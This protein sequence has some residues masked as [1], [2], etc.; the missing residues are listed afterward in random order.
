MDSSRWGFRLQ[1]VVGPNLNLS[2]GHYRTF[3]DLPA[4]RA[5]VEPGIPLLTDLDQMAFEVS[6]QPVQ[7]T[8]GSLNF[9]EPRTNTVVRAEVAFFWDEPVFIPQENI[10][11]LY[12]PTLPLPGWALDLAA[13]LF[14]IDVRDLGLDGLPVNPRSGTIPEKSILRYMIGLDKQMWIR[15][16][17]RTNMFFVSLQYFGQWIPDYDDRL[18]QALQLYPSPVNFSVLKETESVFTALA[19]TMYRKG[20]INP[21]LALAYDVRGAWLIQPSVNLIREPFRFMIQYSAIQGNFTNF[22]AFRD[23]DQITFILTYLLS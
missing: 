9:W 6:W 12:G 3:L 14:G 19:S 17:N 16:L 11:V 21:Q 22:G 20:T 1:G 15:P 7:I 5:V 10:S 2:V 8:G 23:R 4:L 18:R 13:E